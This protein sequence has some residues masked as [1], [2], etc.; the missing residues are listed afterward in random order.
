[1][2]NIHV[3][4]HL[5]QV[6]DWEN[7]YREQMEA[8]ERSGL[9]D[10]AASINI[11]VVGDLEL[12]CTPKGAV[13]KRHETNRDVA[14]TMFMLEQ[15]CQKNR[16][17]KVCFFHS[18]SVTNPSS[19]HT[20]W[21]KYLDYWTLTWWKKNIELLM[22]GD[23]VGTNWHTD[24][25]MGYRPH[26]AGCFWWA[27]GCF[28]NRLNH[29]MLTSPSRFDREFWIGSTFANSGTHIIEIHNSREGR[30]PD[31]WPHYTLEYP[32]N[33][34]HNDPKIASYRKEKE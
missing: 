1:M 16:D 10:A 7:V 20:C 24:T 27:K 25:W 23:C 28:I 15:F 17:A 2:S 21:R 11:G 32:E 29:E 22:D 31:C 33:L 30:Y 12:P 26:F 34:Y 18:K 14:D 19:Q 13:V 8:M 4:Y 5:Y 6:N 9:V 3:F